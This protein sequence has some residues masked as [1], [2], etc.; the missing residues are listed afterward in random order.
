[1]IK[2]IIFLFCFLAVYPVQDITL[3]GEGQ[4]KT[5]QQARK[6]ALSALSESI[7]V[8]VRSQFISS[9]DDKG[10]YEAN[11]KMET[12]SELPLLGVQYNCVKQVDLILCESLLNSDVVTALYERRLKGISEKISTSK[13]QLD[14]I[15]RD[16]RY[17]FLNDVLNDIDRFEKIKIVAQLLGIS[18]IPEVSLNEA[19]IRSQLP[20]YDYI[21]PVAIFDFVDKSGKQPELVENISTIIFSQLAGAQNITLV[22][23]KELDTL[24]NE[25]TLNMSGMVNANQANQI[26]Q[27]I[28]AKI[29]VTG[30]VFE[31]ENTR[32]IVSKIIGTET[33]RVTAATV[34]GD[35]NGSLV[36]LVNKLSEKITKNI[37]IN[38]RS[39]VASSISREERVSSLK[40]KLKLAHKP[41]LII[42]IKEHH[43]NQAD[44]NR[45]AESEMLFYSIE[46]GFEII[47]KDS[48]EAKTADILIVG[49]GFTEFASRKKGIVG[50][51]SRLE[52]KAI[53][54]KTNKILAVD[55]QTGLEV[56]LNEI[57]AAKKALANASAKIAERLLPKLTGM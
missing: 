1:M 42:D 43:I 15:H 26:G 36:N 54:R 16:Q 28:G 47:D 13:N 45:S 30:T 3:T 22:D 51:K 38:A 8:D 50:I 53:D 14:S 2:P 10:A 32:M 48:A 4:G 37:S 34:Q 6:D 11:K 25:A 46:S 56:D 12:V 44:I 33:S 39:L 31:I 27:I 35:V 52:I 17:E 41:S 23:R 40:S 5:Q 24:I 19:T 21:Y 57:F 49:E 7:I 29:I 9:Q 18:D 20:D 55:R